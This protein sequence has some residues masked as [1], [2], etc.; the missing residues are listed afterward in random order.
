MHDG[1]AQRRWTF[2]IEASDAPD[3]LLRVLNPFVVVGAWPCAASL[4]RRAHGVTI[5]IE[6]E[7]LEPR[8]AETLHWRLRALPGVA[9][10]AMSW[11]Q[12]APMSPHVA[13]TALTADAG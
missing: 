1:K 4:E 5:R 3:Q 13:R 10:V 8:R 9:S 12:A 7:P 6:A 2:V 11:R